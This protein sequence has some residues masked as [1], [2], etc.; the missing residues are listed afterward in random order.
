[1]KQLI[2]IAGIALLIANAVC[3][4][5]T[6]NYTT[7][8]GWPGAIIVVGPGWRHDEAG[9]VTLVKRVLLGAPE[10]GRFYLRIFDNVE[11]AQRTV[12]GRDYGNTPCDYHFVGYCTPDSKGRVTYLTYYPKG[13]DDAVG[14]EIEVGHPQIEPPHFGD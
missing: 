6:L 4:G 3:A 10:D 8:R 2:T 5:D 1:M 14:K 11:C 13:P 12:A 9:L 7:I